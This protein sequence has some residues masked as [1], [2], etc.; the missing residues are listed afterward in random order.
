MSTGESRNIRSATGQIVQLDLGRRWVSGV[1]E[2]SH[3]FNVIS[4]I[5]RLNPIGRIRHNKYA[6]C[7][8]TCIQFCPGHTLLNGMH[9]LAGGIFQITQNIASAALQRIE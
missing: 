4:P 5:G 8:I 3:V 9:H 2:Y 6:R 1:E 7:Q